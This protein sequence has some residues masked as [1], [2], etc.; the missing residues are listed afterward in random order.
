[1]SFAEGRKQEDIMKK[2]IFVATDGSD[3]AMAAVDLAAE[4]AAKFDVRLTIGHVLRFGRPSEELARMAEVEH[5]VESVAKKSDVEFQ[6]SPGATG[7]FFVGSRPSGDIVRVVTL[8]GDEI[9]RRASDRAK[10]L[11][12]GT[13]KTV[14]S[15][16][17]PADSIL[18][19]AKEAG[20][21]MI[22][23]GHRGLGRWRTML[24]GSVAQKVTQHAECTV[25]A[26]R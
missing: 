16:G 4:L 26:V 19:M 2:H 3:S 6:L 17:D 8:I 23:L 15:Q 7:D 21:D 18:D 25:V 9:L 11:G 14:S 24:L 12:V 10:E 5:I 20:A 13:V 22:V 1:M